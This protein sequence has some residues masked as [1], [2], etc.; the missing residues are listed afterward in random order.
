MIPDE[1]VP[2]ATLGP[3][4]FRG[5]HRDGNGMWDFSWAFGTRI[6]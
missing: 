2:F 6:A 5:H 1:I 3:S 4:L